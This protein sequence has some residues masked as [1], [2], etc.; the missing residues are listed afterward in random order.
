MEGVTIVGNL[1]VAELVFYI[2][3]LFFLGLVIWLRREDRREGY[4]L[5]DDAT[6]RLMPIDGLLQ[7]PAPK[8]FNTQHGRVSPPTDN[9]R[10]PVDLPNAVRTARWGGSPIEPTGN[11]LLSGVGP[12][13]YA[14]RQDRP[15]VDREGQPRIVPLAAAE[16][17]FISPRDPDPRGMV[18]VGADR[19]VAGTVDEIWVDKADHVIRY[20]AVGGALVPMTMCKIDKGRRVVTCDAVLGSQFAGAPKPGSAGVLTLLDEERITA[21]FG[22]GYLYATPR[23]AEA[24]L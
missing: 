18:M 19:V 21:Y 2:F 3:F 15:D 11:P 8:V 24:K 10:D 6:G 22:G 5:E 14:Q 23:R 1:D 9:G 17:F 16:G 12:A 13:A 20:L 7:V 4:P